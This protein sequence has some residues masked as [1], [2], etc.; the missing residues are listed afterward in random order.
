V[1]IAVSRSRSGARAR[2]VA[3]ARDLAQRSRYAA[4]SLDQ[5]A[6][7]LGGPAG[8]NRQVWLDATNTLDA[9]AGAAAA[10]APD[11]PKVPGD[12]K[13]ANSLTSAL[14]QLR[15][16]LTVFRSAVVEAERTRFE[17]LNPTTEQLDF[18]SRSVRQASATVVA[19]VHTLG[20]GLD[21]VAPA[22][23]AGGGSA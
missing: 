23:P 1:L 19:D 9:L 6:A 2:W 10:L 4:E 16:S 7:V 21:R 18:A 11:A 12:P 13:G 22:T 5:A 20:V 17:L 8:A 14:E 15:S 3:S